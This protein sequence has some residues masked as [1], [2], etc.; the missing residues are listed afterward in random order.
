MLTAA[1]QST[2]PQVQ[3]IY[4]DALERIAERIGERSG[5]EA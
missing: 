1:I 3:D 2:E 4:G 5:G